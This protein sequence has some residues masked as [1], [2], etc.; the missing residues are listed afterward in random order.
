MAITFTQGDHRDWAASVL[1]DW[2]KVQIELL[3]NKLKKCDKEGI[4]SGIEHT[5]ELITK[6]RNK[7]INLN[8]E[9]W[10][11]VLMYVWQER[12]D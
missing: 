2:H 9:E 7:K 3:K 1:E 8:H 4:K 12:C 11:D 10:D 6:L 5:G